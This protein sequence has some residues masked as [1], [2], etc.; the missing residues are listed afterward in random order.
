MEFKQPATAEEYLRMVENFSWL[1]DKELK[2]AEDEISANPGPLQA[3]MLPKL[4]SLVNVTGYMRGQDGVFLNSRPFD[5]SS[6]QSELYKNEDSFEGRLYKLIEKICETTE[7]AAAFKVR[8]EEYY[9]R[10]R[11]PR[12]NP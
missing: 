11:L 5:V 9:I 6:F 4:V 2:A 12:K 8:T 1:V 10:N 3:Q 7:G